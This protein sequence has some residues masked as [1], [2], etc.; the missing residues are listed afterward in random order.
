MTDK[1]IRQQVAGQVVN[2]LY[3]DICEDNGTEPFIGWL[4]DG[5]VFE[6]SGMTE[7]EI[8]RAME[9]ANEIADSVDTLTY[10]LAPGM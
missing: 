1:E 3:N 2:M 4:A 9:I 8:A 5:E 10:K 7:E 6:D